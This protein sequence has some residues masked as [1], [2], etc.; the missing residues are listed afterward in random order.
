[1]IPAP[2]PP[3]SSGAVA[4]PI[5]QG[6]R[7]PGGLPAVTWGALEAFGLFIVGDLAIGQ[8][9]VAGAVLALMGVQQQ[10]VTQGLPSIVGRTSSG[11]GVYF[12][13]P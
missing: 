8:V 11:W 7:G 2:P 4:D 5:E 10:Q 13:L 9:V 1:M 12:S 6:R 3:E